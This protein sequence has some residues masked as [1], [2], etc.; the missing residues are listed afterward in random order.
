MLDTLLPDSIGIAIIP[1]N[2]VSS[3]TKIHNDNN[4]FK[5]RI[6]KKHTLLASIEMPKNLFFPK[7]TETVVL[8]FR[9]GI[10]NEGQQTW[11][12]KLDDGYELL[13]HQK[14]R[15]PGADSDR[16]MK[17]F[18]ADYEG[19]AVS[20]HTFLREVR[21]DEQWV[22][23]LFADNDYQVTTADLQNVVN[24]YIAYLFSNQYV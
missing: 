13:K 9:T 21:Y 5:E 6:L 3:R 20:D 15:T 1:V 14:T 8:V 12:A 23:T 24:E 7:G 2:A 11:F 16:L 10:P 18:L 4:S 17:Q 19:R 22:Y